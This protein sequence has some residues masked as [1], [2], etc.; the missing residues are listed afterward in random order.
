V[1]SETPK[2]EPPFVELQIGKWKLTGFTAGAVLILLLG[3][4]VASCLT[5]PLFQWSPLWTSAAL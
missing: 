5:R 4:L 1:S 3:I 2:N